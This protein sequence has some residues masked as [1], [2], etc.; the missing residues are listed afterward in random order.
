MYNI[1]SIKFIFLTVIFSITIL[2]AEIIN[3]RLSARGFGTSR[4]TAEFDA[5]V[6]V[7][8]QVSGVQLVSKDLST[9]VNE[10]NNKYVNGRE[11]EKHE[12]IEQSHQNIL[13]EVSGLVS[14]YNIL[15]SDRVDGGWEVEIEAIIPRY[16]TP[17]FAPESRRSIGVLNFRGGSQV[18]PK[19]AD[20]FQSALVSKLTQ[21]RKFT[22]VDRDFKS[23]YNLEEQ[24]ILF[25]DMPVSEIA[26]IGASLGLDYMVV[27]KIHDLNSNSKSDF[28]EA[29][30]QSIRSLEGNF[31][32]H[33]RVIVMATRQIKASQTYTGNFTMS[34]SENRL[35]LWNDFLN[36]KAED[37]AI[38]LR[39]NIFP[40]RIIK[41]IPRQ[42]ISGKLAILNEGGD[43]VS[44]GEVYNIYKLGEMMHD[45]Y[46]KEQLGRTETIV[47]K[48]RI[49]SVNPKVSYAELIETSEVF[50]SESGEIVGSGVLCRPV[51]DS[52]KIEKV[53][54]RKTNV[55][56]T[57][58][59]GVLL[60]F[61]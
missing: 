20:L 28:L 49:T 51:I 16:K 30:G 12:F 8:S 21:M 41:V 7:L 52:E 43:S 53:E 58:E 36:K 55:R 22:V 13:T 11:D 10:I 45:P 17:G 19:L 34:N 15:S 56:K 59:N 1:F 44:L 31:M 27:G 50:W 48:L 38:S 54:G 37:I 42:G 9:I 25:G 47:G 46:T 24:N 40:I 3:E 18:D 2:N 57:Q 32:V 26:R 39:N 60:P 5:L 4:S 35:G 33:M 23:E 6:R 61:D 29:T 14:S